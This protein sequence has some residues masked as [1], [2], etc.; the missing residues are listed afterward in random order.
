MTN[1]TGDINTRARRIAKQLHKEYTDHTSQEK[2]D[3]ITDNQ[4]ARITNEQLLALYRPPA[5][6][7]DSSPIFTPQTNPEIQ[8]AN[9]PAEMELEY[10][11]T[12]DNLMQEL[13]E[14]EDKESN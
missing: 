7:H 9:Q 12:C 14:T 11:T 5:T 13:K 8:P 6:S 10:D 3:T 2:E 1:Q 4:D